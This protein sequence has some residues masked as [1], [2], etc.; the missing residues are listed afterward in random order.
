WSLVLL[1]VA[2]SWT[3]PVTRAE[4][5]VATPAEAADRE[6]ASAGALIGTPATPG[7]AFDTLTD[8]V[9]FGGSIFYAMAV[10]AVFVLRRK[11]PNLE[12]PYRTWGYPVTPAI[13]LLAFGGAMTSMLYDKWL[14]TAAG[15][16]LIL[17]GVVAFYAMGGGAKNTDVAQPG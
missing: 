9:I 13:Y 1:L 17:A 12:R 3:A 16:V 14:Q 6:E 4:P 15:S 5:S 7:D 11:M 10:G 2:Y 8:F